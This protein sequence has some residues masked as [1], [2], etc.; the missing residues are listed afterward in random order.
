MQLD[1][2]C[3]SIPGYSNCVPKLPT[4]FQQHSNYSGPFLW[5]VGMFC[6]CSKLS[7]CIPTGNVFQL[8]SNFMGGWRGGGSGGD[9]R[10][11]GKH[12]HHIHTSGVYNFLQQG[13]NS[14][15][16]VPRLL[17]AH[18]EC[19]LVHT[20]GV[21]SLLIDIHTYCIYTIRMVVCFTG[22]MTYI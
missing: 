4:A 12:V 14:C 13:Y 21:F 6:S 18:Y 16:T 3:L 8:N 1:E 11:G 7:N 9:G 20:A 2:N 17:L 5:A 19:T 15:Y 10:G 22:R